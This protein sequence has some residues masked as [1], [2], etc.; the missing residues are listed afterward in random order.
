LY[1]NGRVIW[2]IDRIWVA[3]KGLPEFDFPIDNVPILDEVCWFGDVWGKKPTCRAVIEHCRR[4]MAADMSYPIILAP[5]GDVLDGVH[6]IAR[7]MLE[8]RTTVRAVK[9][10]NMPPWDELIPPDDPR[11]EPEKPFE[12]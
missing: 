7:A 4:I 3:A 10:Q 12:D 5:N 2:F 9:L 1:S 6:R 11:Y 8:G